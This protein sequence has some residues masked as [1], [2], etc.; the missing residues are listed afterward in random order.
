MLEPYVPEFG[1]DSFCK[2]EYYENQMERE[3][4]GMPSISY[5]EYLAQNEDYLLE[6]YEHF[7]SIG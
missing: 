5:D 2:K 6:K 7:L 4:F 1:L 3:A